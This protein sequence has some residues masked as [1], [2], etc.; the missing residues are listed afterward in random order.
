MRRAPSRAAR[1]RVARDRVAPRRFTPRRVARAGVAVA[2]GGVLALGLSACDGL[3]IELPTDTGDI[4]LPELPTSIP[5]PPVV[6][7]TVTADPEPQPTVTVTVT[8]DPLPQPTVT[9]TMKVTPAPVPQPTVT[10][11]ADAGAPQPQPTVTVTV[12]ATPEPTQEPSPSPSPTPSASPSATPTPTASAT[13]E[14]PAHA[15]AMPWW[16]WLAGGIVLASLLAW[17]GI[18]ASNRSAARRRL[19]TARYQVNWFESTLTPHVLS[20]ASAA[21]AVTAWQDGRPVVLDIDRELYAQST[22]APTLVLRKA[23]ADGRIAL[24]EL[25]AALDAGTAADADADA[26]ALR[27]LH[28]RIDAA[29]AKVRAWVAAQVR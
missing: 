5:I 16:P 27:A 8:A 19:E 2:L 4:N 11:T 14:E 26:D 7:E 20:Q 23:A 29:R 3:P 22:Q 28:A 9:E 17:W 15:Q 21:D 6:T 24:A 10:V 25:I 1:D 12:T 18:S 13:P